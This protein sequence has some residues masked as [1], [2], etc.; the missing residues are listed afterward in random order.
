M[1]QITIA[2]YK[3]REGQEPALIELLRRHH[4]ILR[5][6]GLVSE[7]KP[8]VLKSAE[9]TYLEIFEWKSKDAMDAAHKNKAV[10]DLWQRFEV[11]CEYKKL[12]DVKEAQELFASFASVQ[13]PKGL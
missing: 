2:A 7:F 11:A 1:G 4:G 6:Q 10:L 5:L 9:G 8:V 3:P 12:A 13:L